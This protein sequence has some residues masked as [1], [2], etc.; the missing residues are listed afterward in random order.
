MVKAFCKALLIAGVSLLLPE[1]SY[2]SLAAGHTVTTSANLST[3]PTIR[4]QQLLCDPVIGSDGS[5]T[6]ATE[7]LQ[8]TEIKLNV[9]WHLDLPPGLTLQDFV[10]HI[11][12]TP[13]PDPNLGQSDQYQFINASDG[14]S[15]PGYDRIDGSNKITF[16]DQKN[17]ILI[18]G[19]WVKPF[20][21]PSVPFDQDV[22]FANV[23]VQYAD[24]DL[25]GNPIVKQTFDPV[26]A[27][28][29]VFAGDF[30]FVKAQTAGSQ[31]I[32]YTFTGDSIIPKSDSELVSAPE[33]SSL[34]LLAMGAVGWVARRRRAA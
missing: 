22:N 26:L 8:I 29:T 1:V 19:I 15:L 12:V 33:P 4:K 10:Q 30:S 6:G 27:T 14:S 25:Q 9:L 3:N 34:T 16:D 13:Y 17:D 7:P 11:D 23:I 18:E 31:P 32:T 21:Q 2:G 5:D 20:D 24:K 28:A